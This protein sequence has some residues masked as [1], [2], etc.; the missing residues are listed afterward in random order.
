MTEAFEDDLDAN[1]PFL[2]EA[3]S[4]TRWGIWHR[5]PRQDFADFRLSIIAH[6]KSLKELGWKPEDKALAI[7]R[8]VIAGAFDGQILPGI[9]KLT[10]D[11]FHDD[12]ITAALAKARELGVVL[13]GDAAIAKAKREA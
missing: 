7:M 3:A 2:D 12:V 9:A 1:L 8:E 13:P 5:L 10:R 4:A 6:A 11:G